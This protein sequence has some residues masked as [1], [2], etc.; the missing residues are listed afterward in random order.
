M[1][2]NFQR[3]RPGLSNGLSASFLTLIVG[4]GLMACSDRDTSS[5]TVERTKARPVAAEAELPEVLA[6]IGEEQVT[7]DEVRGRVGGQLDQMTNSYLQQRYT[8]LD[9]TLQ[10]IMRDRL[11]AAEA[12]ER[13]MSVNELIAEE[14]GVNLEVTEADIAA[15]YEENKSR[16]QDRTLDQARDQIADHLRTTRRDEAMAALED[17][18]SEEHGVVYH[19][20]PFRVELENGGAPALGPSDAAV[21]LVEFSD[22]ECPYCS[23]FFPTFEQIKERYGD[24]IQIVYRQFPL[25]S[26]HASAFKAAEASLCANEQGKFW[27]FHDLL[28]QDQSR[29]AVRDLKEKA[30]R[31]GLDQK[32]FDTCLDTGRY[33]EQVQD[34]LAAGQTAGVTGT[35]ALF[36]NGIPIAGGAVAFEVVAEALDR[37]LRRAGM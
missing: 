24:R 13:G 8:L 5:S 36:V 34:D 2:T 20:Q 16:L 37:E 9:E 29:L 23:R 18:L 28:F 26:I 25:T 10:Q 14:T 4:L 17:R 27:A 12:D 15:F 31:L 32:E 3:A 11:L 19:M 33:V 6:T 1:I 22:F 35:P 21:T 30:G 7:L